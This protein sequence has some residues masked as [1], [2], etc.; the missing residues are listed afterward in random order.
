MNTYHHTPRDHLSH[1]YLT[2]A[3]VPAVLLLSPLESE[4]KLAV[5]LG[6]LLDRLMGDLLDYLLEAKLDNL[7]EVMLDDL[8]GVMLVEMS[9]T[10]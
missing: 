3:E 7:T 8:T 2:V 5:V 9:A 6:D 1:L 10:L 4:A